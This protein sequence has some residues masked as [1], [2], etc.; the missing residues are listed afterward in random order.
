MIN[1]EK[2]HKFAYQKNMVTYIFDTF[3]DAVL[4]ADNNEMLIG[5]C[6]DEWIEISDELIFEIPIEE[7]KTKKLVQSFLN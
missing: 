6:K 7:L 4:H 3:D 1:T 5:L 2:N